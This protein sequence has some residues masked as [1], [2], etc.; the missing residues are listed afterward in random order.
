[1]SKLQKPSV[2]KREHPSLQT[3]KYL[4]FFQLLCVI[5]ALLDPDLDSGYGSGSTDL[6]ES[7]SNTDPDPKSCV[8]LGMADLA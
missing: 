4:H 1:M 2:L 7:G 3:M 5:F 8:T 6:I